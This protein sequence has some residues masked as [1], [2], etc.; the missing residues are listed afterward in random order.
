M[1]D[2][3]SSQREPFLRTYSLGIE[4]PGPFSH[5]ALHMLPSTWMQVFISIFFNSFLTLFSPEMVITA[6]GYTDSNSALFFFFLKVKPQRR[7][8]MNTLQETISQAFLFP[9]KLMI[10]SRSYIVFGWTDYIYTAKLRLQW[11]C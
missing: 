5:F 9:A 10:F 7:S 1:L 2:L 8:E 6:K 11:V 4:N 3:F